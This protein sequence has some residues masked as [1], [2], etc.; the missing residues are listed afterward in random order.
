M[1]AGV[2]EAQTASGDGAWRSG[3]GSSELFLSGT[4]PAETDC[5]P[6]DI[7]EVTPPRDWGTSLEL[8]ARRLLER[9]IARQ[10]ESIRRGR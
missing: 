10:L 3:C 9:F 4:E 8:R 5:S 7:P 2:T 1:P 6:F